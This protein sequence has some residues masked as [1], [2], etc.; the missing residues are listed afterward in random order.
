MARTEADIQTELDAVMTAISAL[1][2][3]PDGKLIDY[4]SGGRTFGKSAR[5]R[6]L[7][8]LAKDLREELGSLPCEEETIFEDPV[9]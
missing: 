6:E 7:R 1:V 2:A 5:L 3:D 8:A 9:I 4:T